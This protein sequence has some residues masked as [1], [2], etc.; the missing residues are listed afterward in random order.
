[1]SAEKKA[2]ALLVLSIAMCIGAEV[3][4]SHYDIGFAL[5]CTYMFMGWSVYVLVGVFVIH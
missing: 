1:M 2:V 3:L 4:D 5:D